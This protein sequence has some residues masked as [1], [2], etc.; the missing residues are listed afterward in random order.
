MRAADR[1]AGVALLAGGAVF[2]GTALRQYTYWSPTG[3]GSAFL[4]FWL[5]LALCVLALVLLA[6]ALR[7]PGPGPAWRPDRAGAV[8]LGVVVGLTAAFVAAMP[9]VGMLL[10]T[11]LFLVVLL[12]GLEG[13]RW[14]VAAAIALGTAAVNYLVF[15]YWLRVPFPVGPLGF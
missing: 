13:Y 4:P 5:G 6:G 14:P 15:T 9:W 7:A 3:P 2:A 11:V 12:R 10:G 1:V 8:R